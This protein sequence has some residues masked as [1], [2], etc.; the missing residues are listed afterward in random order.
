MNNEPKRRRIGLIVPAIF[1]FAIGCS[2]QPEL[3]PEDTNA[4]EIAKTAISEH[5]EWHAYAEF[6]RPELDAETGHWT[7][8]VWRNK[9]SLAGSLVVD[10]D[11]DGKVISIRPKF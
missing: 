8:T 10:I 9:Q 3:T 2:S 7:V 4:I 5:P 1:A 6:D 11:E